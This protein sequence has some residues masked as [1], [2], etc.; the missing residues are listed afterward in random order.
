MD[1]AQVDLLSRLEELREK[2]EAPCAHSSMALQRG[3]CACADAG[4]AYTHQCLK[5]VPILVEAVRKLEGA[6]E[7]MV[8]EVHAYKRYGGDIT[9]TISA[10]GLD[11]LTEVR[12]MLGRDG[13]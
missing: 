11:A 5:A 7:R 4:A 1:D 8:D 12:T 2:A 6:L 10:G 13:K 3:D 9:P